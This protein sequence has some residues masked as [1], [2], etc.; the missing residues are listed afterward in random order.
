M[1]KSSMALL[2]DARLLHYTYDK[3]SI[4]VKSIYVYLS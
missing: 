1:K 3:G 4:L 2:I